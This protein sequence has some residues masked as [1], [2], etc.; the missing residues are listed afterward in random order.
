MTVGLE[1]SVFSLN[2]AYPLRR[3]SKAQLIELLRSSIKLEILLNTASLKPASNSFISPLRHMR[4]SP[5]RRLLAQPK[6]GPGAL[7]IEQL[8][9]IHGDQG[10]VIR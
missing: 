8:I 7:E 3:A 2:R 5:G 4:L 10:T 1:E 6:T 9:H